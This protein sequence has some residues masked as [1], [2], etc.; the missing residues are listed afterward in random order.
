MRDWLE[1]IMR[2][3][4]FPEE[5]VAALLAEWDDDRGTVI[6][7]AIDDFTARYARGE[8]FSYDDALDA[9]KAGA[10]AA[11]KSEYPAQ[12][13]FF[14]CLARPLRERYAHMGIGEEIYHDSMLDLRWKLDECREVYG[15]WGI[16]VGWWEPGFFVPD[17]FTLGRLQYEY[18]KFGHDYEGHGF[19]LTPDT[20]VLGM[21]IPSCGPLLPELCM[22][23]FRRA[24]AFYRDRFAPGPTVFTVD[25][26]LLYPAHRDFLPGGSNI[27]KFM[28]FF[29]IFKFSEHKGKPSWRIFGADAKKPL[30][31]LPRDTGLR[32]AYA[33]RLS[34]GEPDGSGCGVFFFDGEKIL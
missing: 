17:R 3:L 32:R 27:L 14:L 7:A 18:V 5:A 33:E 13:L 15:V 6:A 25:T 11:G 12:M 23:S 28:D 22:D 34:R 8:D 30:E 9:I 20:M 16:A 29:D 21:H 2:T 19:T 1:N 31:E 4:T 10:A 26:W 24:H